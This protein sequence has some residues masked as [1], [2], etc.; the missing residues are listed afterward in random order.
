MAKL[1]TEERNKLPDSAFAYID[2]SG[3]RHLPTHDEEHARNAI[4]FERDEERAMIEFRKHLGWY[5]RG[6]PD[7][8]ALRQKLFEV[9]SLAEAERLLEQYLQEY[10]AVAA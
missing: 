8:R 5:T 1:T 2:R 3:E 9:R 6:L 7:G 4:A 10:E